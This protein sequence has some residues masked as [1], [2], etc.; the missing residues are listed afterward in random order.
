MREFRGQFRDGKQPRPVV[1]TAL[2]V[3]GPYKLSIGFDLVSD[4]NTSELVSSHSNVKL[5]ELFARVVAANKL[6]IRNVLQSSPLQPEY[7]NPDL[8]T[9]GIYNERPRG[10]PW[11]LASRPDIPVFATVC[12]AQ[13][14]APCKCDELPSDCACRVLPTQIAKPMV[15][16]GDR[17][18]D[19]SRVVPRSAPMAELLADVSSTLGLGS[20]GVEPEHSE[21]VLMF[22]DPEILRLYSVAGMSIRL[23]LTKE[24]QNAE[25]KL[26]RLLLRKVGNDG[27]GVALDIELQDG[28]AYILL[29]ERGNAEHLHGI[30]SAGKKG[31]MLA[32]HR[33]S[34]TFFRAASNGKRALP[35]YTLVTTHVGAI[36][37]NGIVV[38]YA[39]FAAVHWGYTCRLRRLQQGEPAAA[40][41]DTES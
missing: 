28:S 8:C 31:K 4:M 23:D 7:L 21:R 9:A 18:S 19:G 6:Q 12:T 3:Y 29:G 33:D 11:T 32:F 25:Q 41:S 1:T 40:D 35:D 30:A 15:H 36:V 37:V 24:E 16:K 39:R 38:G 2:C 14:L 20:E 26:P 17:T 13:G 10:L 5:P 34:S 22:I 27:G